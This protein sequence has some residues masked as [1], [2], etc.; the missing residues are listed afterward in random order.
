MAG[1]RSFGCER[2]HHVGECASL[3]RSLDE[4]LLAECREEHD[5]CDVVLAELLGGGD[6]IEQRHLDVHH[7]EVWT[8]LGRER[9]CCLAV[10]GLAHDVEAVVAKGLD[11]VETDE[12]LVFCNDDA[13]GGLC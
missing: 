13:T 11:D 2:L 12:R 10:A 1:S 6:A 8:E 3:R 5:G 7:D 4:F 9:D